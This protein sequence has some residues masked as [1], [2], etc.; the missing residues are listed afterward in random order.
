[1]GG[2][3]TLKQASKQASKGKVRSFL[4]SLLGFGNGCFV[5]SFT[6]CKTAVSCYFR[7]CCYVLEGEEYL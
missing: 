4:L 2:N 6:S 5:G 3:D 7:L 1:M